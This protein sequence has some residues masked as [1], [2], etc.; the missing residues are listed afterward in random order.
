MK[1]IIA[2]LIILCSV[3]FLIMSHKKAYDEGYK[4]G[5]FIEREKWRDIARFKP[6]IIR[7]GMMN[8]VVRYWEDVENEK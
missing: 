7:V 1:Q 8:Y 4:E 6:N 2:S 3:L 5:V